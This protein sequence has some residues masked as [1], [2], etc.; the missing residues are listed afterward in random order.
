ML[1]EVEQDEVARLITDQYLA[2]LSILIA[3]ND[4]CR[5]EVVP[6]ISSLETLGRV[7]FN[8]LLLYG[9]QEILARFDQEQV[10][11]VLILQAKYG[12]ALDLVQHRD[13]EDV[14]GALVREA[15]DLVVASPDNP[16]DLVARSHVHQVDLLELI[17][18]QIVEDH[19]KIMESCSYASLVE[20]GRLCGFFSLRLTVAR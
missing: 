11:I 3:T 9:E 2:A 13:A 12:T 16:D 18:V 20:H 10:Y 5:K 15:H 19:V 4:V 17:Q 1:H 7:K 6:R 14:D 8:F